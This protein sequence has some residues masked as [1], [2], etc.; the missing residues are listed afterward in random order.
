MYSEAS[1][2]ELENE[3][4][5]SYTENSNLA[6]AWYI[7][8]RAQGSKLA[9]SREFPYRVSRGKREPSQ[10]GKQASNT[11][12]PHVPCVLCLPVD[13]LPRRCSRRGNL[14]SAYVWS[15]YPFRPYPSRTCSVSAVPLP[16][17]DQDCWF[18]ST[19]LVRALRFITPEQPCSLSCACACRPVQTS[20]LLVWYTRHALLLGESA[21]PS[22]RS[23]RRLRQL[24]PAKAFFDNN[25]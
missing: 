10:A 8:V 20:L 25:G 22:G 6:I 24:T 14:S 11:C 7:M 23:G 16:L 1:G 13:W 17:L 19:S 3:P 9:A 4:P 18:F 2:A 5:L 21:T 15:D 12:F